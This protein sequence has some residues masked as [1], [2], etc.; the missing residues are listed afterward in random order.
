MR[1][2][3]E[4]PT[5]TLKEL[6]SSVAEE[7]VKVQRSNISSTLH[8]TG[9]AETNEPIPPREIKCMAAC[10]DFDRMHNNDS[11]AVSEKM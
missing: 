7:E 6:K 4:R 8:S 9:R 3:T 1:D 2:A 11:H 10:L 5:I